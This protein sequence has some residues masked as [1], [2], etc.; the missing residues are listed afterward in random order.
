M[1]FLVQTLNASQSNIIVYWKG[2]YFKYKQI[3]KKLAQM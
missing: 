3:E 1:E 2:V